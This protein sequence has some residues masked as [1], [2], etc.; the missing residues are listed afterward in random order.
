MWKL[1]FWKDAVERALRTVA[2]TEAA[3]LVA[4]GTGLLDTDWL[5]GLSTSVMAGVISLLFSISGE[6]VAPN[7][8]ASFTSAVVPRRAIYRKGLDSMGVP[9]PEPG[10]SGGTPSDYDGRG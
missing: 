1:V 10:R 3:V 2:Q 8:T 9:A 4:A 6:V 7:G 5:A